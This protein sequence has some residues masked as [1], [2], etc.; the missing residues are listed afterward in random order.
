[1]SKVNSFGSAAQLQV[2]D[3]SYQIFR[4]DSVNAKTLPYSLKILLENMLRTEDGADRKSV[5]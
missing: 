4:L 2:G 5:V 3:K 1:M